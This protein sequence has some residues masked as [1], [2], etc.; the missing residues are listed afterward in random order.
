MNATPPAVVER[1]PTVESEA[2]FR[3]WV[4]EEFEHTR[5]QLKRIGEALDLLL[6]LAGHEEKHSES[7]DG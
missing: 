6:K 3:V 1:A 4:R 5:A 2:L 7:V